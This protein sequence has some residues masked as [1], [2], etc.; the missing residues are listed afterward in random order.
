[1]LPSCE[2]GQDKEPSFVHSGEMQ[3]EGQDH[4]HSSG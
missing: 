4:C 3:G 1:M 2:Q